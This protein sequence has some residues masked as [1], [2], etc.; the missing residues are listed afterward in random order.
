MTPW[1]TWYAVAVFVFTW[2]LIANRQLRWIPLGRAAGALL[3]A[4]LMTAGGVL[5]PDE[6]FAAVD[7]RTIALLLGMMLIV[8]LLAEAKLLELAAARLLSAA[9]TPRGA[10]ATTSIASGVL[11]AVL[12]N[13]TVCLFAT[14]VVIAACR[15]AS[16][17]LAPFL[18][19]VATSSNVGSLATLVGNPQLMLIGSQSGIPFGR[20]FAVMAPTSAVLL[21]LNTAFLLLA[22][23]RALPKTFADAHADAPAVAVER[24][25]ATAALVVVVGV[26]VAFFADASM[27]WA[28][29]AGA[30]ALL[31]LR[32][33]DPAPTFAAVDWKLLVFFGGLFI[34][35]KA[36]D[37]TGL[38][39]EL[40]GRLHDTPA[41]VPWLA[42]GSNLFSNVP[43]VLLAAPHLGAQAGD[44]AA[45]ERGWFVLGLVT[46]LAGNLTLIGSAANL[47]V[48][49]QADLSFKTYLKFG[50]PSAAA[51]IAL[52]LWM[53]G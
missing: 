47:I 1:Q 31:W 28:A 24:G 13:D 44:P 26:F 49:E 53:L 42:V 10:L 43:M 11:A 17:P 12:V 16:L 9:R 15:R 14:P 48:A 25:R 19:A 32:G 40:M 23:G 46:T 21:A 5:T 33:R 51:T 22:Y 29:L 39:A 36:I 20:W 30:V 37:R 2:L 4:V 3:G 34:V 27:P 18:M 35:T 8:A 52:G 38:S 6:A 7:P 50:A 41:Y 45:A